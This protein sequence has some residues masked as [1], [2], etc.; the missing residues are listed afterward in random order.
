ML[1]TGT[2]WISVPCTH[3]F[4]TGSCPHFLLRESRRNICICGMNS[5]TPSFADTQKTE[6]A[7][8]LILR[9]LVNNYGQWIC[10]ILV[11]KQHAC[12]KRRVHA[13]Y[14]R[15]RAVRLRPAKRLGRQSRE[16]PLQ[17]IREL[18]VPILLAIS[19]YQ[20]ENYT[21]GRK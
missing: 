10:D 11:S 8:L 21:W 12:S 16:P 7:L 20:L 5:F 1:Q 3:P 17:R 19:T 15:H 6:A 14:E 2:W 9:L 18:L 13:T 4:V